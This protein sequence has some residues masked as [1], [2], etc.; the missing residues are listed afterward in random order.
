MAFFSLHAKI[1]TPFCHGRSE[2]LALRMSESFNC[3]ERCHTKKQCTYESLAEIE[4]QNV[5][6]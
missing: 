3:F 1:E 5:S 4:P 2:K 6:S